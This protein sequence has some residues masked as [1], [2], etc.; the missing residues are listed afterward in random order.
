MIKVKLLLLKRTPVWFQ[1]PIW[2][3]K[4]MWNFSSKGSHAFSTGTRHE[5]TA[6]HT[7]IFLK[8]R[9]PTA[10]IIYFLNII[11]SVS[12][13]LTRKCPSLNFSFLLNHFLL[14]SAPIVRLPYYPINEYYCTQ[15]G[16]SRICGPSASASQMLGL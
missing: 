16:L 10:H 1:A 9:I 13:I 5:F 6:I 2:K 4:T 3:L 11:T 15:S 7:C 14:F 12:I 8:M